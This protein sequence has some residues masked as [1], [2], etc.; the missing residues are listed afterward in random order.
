MRRAAG[1]VLALILLIAGCA[2]A[3]EAGQSEQSAPQGEQEAQMKITL[4]VGGAMFTATLAAGEAADVF[5]ARL[6]MTLEMRE[7]NGN[8]KYCYLD[9][10]LPADASCPN[11]IAAGDLMLFGSSCVVLFYE[12]F[13]TSY[14]YTPLGRLDD[15]SGLAAAAGDG[16]VTVTFALCEG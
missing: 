2:P 16:P 4:D 12:S 15:A 11:T 8:E 10:A 1:A 9:D 6:P 14:S 5:A 13:S 3:Q 7:L